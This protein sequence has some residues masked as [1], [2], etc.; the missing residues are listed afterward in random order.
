VVFTGGT[1]TTDGFDSTNRPDFKIFAVGKNEEAA[2]QYAVNENNCFNFAP[3][4][5]S[6][7][8]GRVK[9]RRTFVGAHNRHAAHIPH[10]LFVIAQCHQSVRRVTL[11]HRNF[12]VRVKRS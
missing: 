6:D 11:R 7:I 1:Q 9:F 8:N 5:V 10:V 3:E 12:V 4:H 2:N